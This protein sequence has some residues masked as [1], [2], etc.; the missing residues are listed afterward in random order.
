MTGETPQ[1][2]ART[3]ARWESRGGSYYVE[4]RTDPWGYSYKAAGKAVR[5]SGNF[6]APTDEAAIAHMESRKDDYQP[7]ANKTPMRRIF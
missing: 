5:A 6:L 4:L 3:L 1:F 7:D 2:S